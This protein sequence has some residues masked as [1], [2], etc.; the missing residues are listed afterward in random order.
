VNS[1]TGSPFGPGDADTETWVLA[2]IAAIVVGTAYSAW[3]QLS[4]SIVASI[5]CVFTL[6][7]MILEGQND[8][9]GAISQVGFAPRDLVHPLDLYKLLTS[10][11]AH[12]NFSHLLFNLLA[13]ILLGLAFEQRIGTRPFILIFLLSGLVGTLVFAAVRWNDPLSVVVGASGAISGVLGGFARLFPNERMSMILFIVPLPPMRIWTIV[14]IFVL[15]Q[16][17]FIPTA[18]SIAVEAHLGGL[19]GGIL[20]S[21][22]VMRLPLRRKVKRT[23]AL[24]SLRRLATTPDLKADIQR[25]EAETVPDVRSAWIEHFLSNARCPQ[26]GSRL[27]VSRDSVMCEKGHLI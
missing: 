17:L 24:S 26:C 2:I 21:P 13:L 15:L 6:I 25:I 16:F 18:P 4:Y 10:M 1:I 22:L 7:V 19:A 23:I 14:A 3:K 27:R 20:L 11:F 9:N 8:W 5:V 12:A